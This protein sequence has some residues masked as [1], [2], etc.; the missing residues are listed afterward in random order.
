MWWVWGLGVECECP[1][2]FL[3]QGGFSLRDHRL[4]SPGA[5]FEQIRNQGGFDPKS[6][7]S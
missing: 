5:L 6:H 1:R 2:N 4:E 7:L 3:G